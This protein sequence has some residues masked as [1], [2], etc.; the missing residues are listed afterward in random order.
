MRPT[1]QQRIE[2][3]TEAF[4][5]P[6]GWKSVLEDRDATETC[7]PFQIYDLQIKCRYTAIAL[8]IALRKMG[9]G[10][11]RATWSDCCRESIQTVNEFNN[12]T[13]IKNQETIQRWHLLYRRNDECFPNPNTYK[14]DGRKTLPRLLEENPD[15]QDA[16]VS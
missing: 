13:Y 9:R 4:S 5:T 8:R 1:I 11:G 6:N 14:K 2:R 3:L 16:I 12:T 15:L 7:S 10:P